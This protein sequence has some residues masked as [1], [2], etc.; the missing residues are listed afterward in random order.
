MSLEQDNESYGM[1][2]DIVIHTLI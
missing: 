1:T 2:S